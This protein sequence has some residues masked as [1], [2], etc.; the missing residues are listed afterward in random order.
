MSA[1]NYKILL[2]AYTTQSLLATP[3]KHNYFEGMTA[4]DVFTSKSKRLSL[5][6]S[7]ALS[8]LKARRSQRCVQIHYDSVVY[9]YTTIVVTETDGD[10]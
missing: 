1:E 5:A 2:R 6:F 3:W 10:N 9:K 4:D 7:G 8:R